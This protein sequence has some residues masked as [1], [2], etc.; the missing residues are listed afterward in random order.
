MRKTYNLELR[1]GV[2]ARD[3]LTTNIQHYH[4][5]GDLWLQAEWA[6]TQEENREE[7]IDILNAIDGRRKGYFLQRSVLWMQ[8]E[9]R[10]RPQT[11]AA[12]NY[13]RTE[14]AAR[15]LEE[16]EIWDH[17]VWHQHFARPSGAEFYWDNLASRKAE[18]F[19]FCCSVN[20]SRLKRNFVRL[21][22]T[23]EGSCSRKALAIGISI[24]ALISTCFAWFKLK[25]VR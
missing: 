19:I 8:E 12:I 14:A 5:L 9:A 4:C 21:F 15:V 16:E 13:L 18:N 24:I 20:A 7:K 1:R 3:E 25:V 6:A 2:S 10:N 17:L 22:T 11:P 23:D